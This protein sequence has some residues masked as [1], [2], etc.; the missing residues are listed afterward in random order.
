MKLENVEKE[1]KETIEIAAGGGSLVVASDHS[2]HDGIP[3]ENIWAMYKAVKKHG[4]YKI[5]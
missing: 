3:M 5:G 1:V 4:V 2:L